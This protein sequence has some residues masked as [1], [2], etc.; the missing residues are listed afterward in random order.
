MS[1]KSDSKKLSTWILLAPWILTLLVFWVYPFCH[2]FVMSLT[3]YKAISNTYSFIG[4]ENYIHAFND[5]Y[6][7]R[8]LLNTFIFSFG[9]VPVTTAIAIFLAVL[10]ND[11]LVRF[12]EFFRA[13]YF[14]PSVTSMIVIAL[15]FTNLYA[16]DG[17][18]N[19]I[20]EMLNLPYPESGWLLEPG[21]ALLSIMAMDV[22]LAVG[23][24]MVLFLAGMQTISLDLYDAADLAGASA[25][26][27][28]WKIT[29][30]LIRPTLLFVIVINTIKSFQIF[31]EIYVMT[32]GGPMGRTL[33]MV[34]LVYENAFNK[35]DMM[36]Y[37]SSIAFILFG[38][39]MLFSFLQLKL[40]RPAD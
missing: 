14:M 8:A 39:L 17:Y 36:G 23:Y 5:E 24:Y 40:I 3:E 9:T 29:F 31:M 7:R 1:Q 21:T 25:W 20:L 34:Y 37:A 2:A 32:K 27:K 22:W 19:K 15:I 18:I 38:I 28:F 26:Q 16:G 6:F 35:I 33:T 12:K 30:P 11:K 10:L 4:L 13:T